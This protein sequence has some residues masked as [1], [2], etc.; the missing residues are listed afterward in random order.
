[1]ALI[2]LNNRGVRN[3]STFGSVT[4]GSLT[5]IKKLT[6]SQLTKRQWLQKQKALELDSHW[7]LT[8][9]SNEFFTADLAQ[10][11]N[12]ITDEVKLDKILLKNGTEQKELEEDKLLLL[13]EKV[14][15]GINER[16]FIVQQF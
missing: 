8:P 4:G 12:I 2:K 9:D 13:Q 10:M 14:N 5:F 1:M 6:A 16:G 7:Y 3:V 15:E 11:S